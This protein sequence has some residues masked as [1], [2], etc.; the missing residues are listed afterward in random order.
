MYEYTIPHRDNVAKSTHREPSMPGLGVVTLGQEAQFLVELA[1]VFAAHSVRPDGACTCGDRFC[2]WPPNKTVAKHPRYHKDDLA[3]GRDD[4]TTDVMQLATWWARWPE[5]NIGLAT[6]DGL[7]VLDV[8]GPE[9]RAFLED[10]ALLPETLRART[11]RV[12]GGEHWYFLVPDGVEVRNRAKVAPGLDVRGDGGY[13]IAPPSLHASGARYEWVDPAVEVAMCPMWLLELVR[14]AEPVERPAMVPVIRAPGEVSAYA[15]AALEREL[16]TLLGAGEG[17]RNDTLN[18]VAFNLGTLVAGGELPEGLVRDEVWG[19][20]RGIGL[21]ER[22]T[23]RTIDS[24]LRASASKPRVAPEPRTR[25]RDPHQS[26]G[27]TENERSAEPIVAGPFTA[28]QPLLSGANGH[29]APSRVEYPL[30]VWPSQVAEFIEATAH[31]VCVEPAAVGT[32]CLAVVGAALGRARWLD[33]K[34]EGGWIERPGIYAGLVGP[35]SRRKSPAI[36]AAA[37]PLETI[38]REAAQRWAREHEEWESAPS[39]KEPEISSPVVKDVTTE[40]LALALK[41]HPRGVGMLADE[42]VGWLN[43]MGQYKGGKG[44]DRQRWIEAFEGRSI[45]VRRVGRKPLFVEHPCVSVLGGI[46]PAV[47]AG[48]T[49]VDDGLAQRFLYCVMPKVTLDVRPDVP[50]RTRGTWEAIVRGLYA[51]PEAELVCEA[52]GCL[53]EARRRILDVQAGSPAAL[54]TWVGKGEKHLA[55]IALALAA[56]WEVCGEAP[57][58]TMEAVAR[59]EDLWGFYA[60]QARELFCGDAIPVASY[61]PPGPAAEGELERWIRAQGEQ[62]WKR[63][64]MRS[65]PLRGL[66]AKGADEVIYAAAARGQV[67]I[68]QVV[69]EGGGKTRTLLRLPE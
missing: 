17:S 40:V 14:V 4:A 31:S 35:P 33:I 53:V 23:T 56:V 51:L 32:A 66:S 38:H 68:E 29:V 49:A 18:A 34:G 11:G 3:H 15:R 16:E 24:A 48:L 50:R 25:N 63:D 61:Q 42:L 64:A 5:A 28:G 26:P 44:N 45:D 30:G 12:D 8:D 13:V 19:V 9:G 52:P 59:A 2:V 43:S 27:I 6:G 65:G 22:E 21:E 69:Q 36:W 67:V 41:A 58:L 37:D 20:A 46:Q 57:A 62:A 60:D 47:F 1:P 39:R 7:M 55:R 54:E 10:K